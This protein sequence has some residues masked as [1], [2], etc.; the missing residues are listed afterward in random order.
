MKGIFKFRPSVRALHSSFHVK[1]SLHVSAAKQLTSAAPVDH[2]LYFTSSIL[3]TERRHVSTPPSP[4]YPPNACILFHE[5][6][7]RRN[8]LSF[9]CF[10]TTLTLG[11][12]R[13]RAVHRSLVP[14]SSLWPACKQIWQFCDTCSWWKLQW[15]AGGAPSWLAGSFGIRCSSLWC[16]WQIWTFQ[17]QCLG[18]VCMHTRVILNAV[19]MYCKSAGG[20]SKLLSIC[21]GLAHKNTWSSGEPMLASMNAWKIKWVLHFSV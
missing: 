21:S 19:H 5:S 4:P 2:P 17:S 16:C 6:Y 3:L 10:S 15:C 7:D 18:Q 1:L 9:F 8:S 20:H 12:G 13:W 14:S 11:E